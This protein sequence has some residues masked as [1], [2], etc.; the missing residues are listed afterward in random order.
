MSLI[1]ETDSGASNF[2]YLLNSATSVAP[3]RLAAAAAAAVAGA[4]V[5]VGQYSGAPYFVVLYSLRS[6][7][8]A[9]AIVHFAEKL[10]R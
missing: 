6:L 4:A 1:P 5:A 8:P 3:Y 9:G 2:N 10:L 7:D